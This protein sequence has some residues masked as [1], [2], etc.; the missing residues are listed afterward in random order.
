MSGLKAALRAEGSWFQPHPWLTLFLPE[1][2][3]RAIVEETLART[4][5][6]DIGDSGLILL[7]PLRAWDSLASAKKQYDPKRILAPGQ[8]LFA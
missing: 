2:S 7:Y 1:H 6:A 3:V 8:P 4:T 5:R